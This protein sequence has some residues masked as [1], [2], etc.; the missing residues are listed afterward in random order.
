MIIN[1]KLCFPL[2]FIP[3]FMHLVFTKWQSFPF[4]LFIFVL[5]ILLKIIIKN[6]QIPE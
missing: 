1:K 3:S 5:F 2:L 4:F 6:M